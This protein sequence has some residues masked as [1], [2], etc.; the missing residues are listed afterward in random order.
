MGRKSRDEDAINLIQEL[1]AARNQIPACHIPR[2][3]AGHF[4]FPIPVVPRI[5]PE[6]ASKNPTI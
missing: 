3:I 2:P 5:C 4:N 6:I 1:M